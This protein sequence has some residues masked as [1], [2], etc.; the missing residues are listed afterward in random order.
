MSSWRTDEEDA[1]ERCG[2]C[3]NCT[4]SPEALEKFG[5]IAR[6]GA[7]RLLRVAQAAR[8]DLTLSQLYD[9]ARGKDVA[10]PAGKGRGRRKSGAGQAATVDVEGLTGDKNDLSREVSAVTPYSLL[11]SADA[12]RA[13]YRDVVHAST[14]RGLSL[15]RFPVDCV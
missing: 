3:D 4:R 12:R 14:R 15:L 9:L 7:W 2:H 1:L 13:A 5:P 10:A 6:L 8:R 11:S